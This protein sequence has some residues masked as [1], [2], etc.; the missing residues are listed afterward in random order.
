MKMVLFDIE[1][2]YKDIE[3]SFYYLKYLLIDGFGYLEVVII[4]F[5]IILGDIVVVVYLKDERY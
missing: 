4:C 3:G 1:V 5:E 2:I